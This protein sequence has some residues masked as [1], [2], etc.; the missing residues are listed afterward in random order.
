MQSLVN[1][2]FRP[3]FNRYGY[4]LTP[5]RA[6]PSDFSQQD[7]ALYEAVKP[8]TLTSPE[9]IYAL[10]QA[11]RYVVKHNIAGSFVECGVWR[12]GSVLAMAKTLLAL[13]ETRDI[14]LFD[15]FEGM[16]KPGTVDGSE[17]N[18]KF[19]ETKITDSSSQWT[20]AALEDVKQVVCQ[21]AYSQDHFHFQQGL[22]EQ[23]IP[24]QAPSEIALLRLDTDWY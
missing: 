8:Y 14:Y 23:T 1:R 21:T 7:V 15:T 11:V 4:Q 19:E 12:G 9:R 20:Y 16:P 2:F 22:V 3:L 13:G 10:T 18:A 6:I 24:E 5:K 17:A